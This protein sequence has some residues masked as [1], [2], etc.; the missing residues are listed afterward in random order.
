MWPT[1][2]EI[3]REVR[4]RFC[5][6]ENVP[7][8]LSS[9]YFG[10]I[11]EDL[12]ESGYDCRW[13]ILSAAEVGAPHQRKRL[14]IVAYTKHYGQ[15]ASQIERGTSSRGNSDSARKETSGESSRC[16]EQHGELADSQRPQDNSQWGYSQCRRLCLGRDTEAAQQDY[17]QADSNSPGGCCKV[18]NP[19]GKGLEGASRKCIQGEIPR[20]SFPGRDN[21][22]QWWEAEPDVGRVAN[23]VAARVDRLKAIG[24]GQVPL[25][26]AKAW[27]ILTEGLL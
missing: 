6:L 27:E 15:L 1:T 23:G 18:E 24:N 22:L 3:V 21:S 25:V 26:A 20:S 8:L 17:G 12:V 13:R 10:K 9:G 16:G 11:L 7:G 19:T 4:P 5:F 2:L 14:W